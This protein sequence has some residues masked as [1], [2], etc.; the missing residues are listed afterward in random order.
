MQNLIQLLPHISSYNSQLNTPKQKMV[1]N[2]FYYFSFIVLKQK[3]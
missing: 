3:N 2:F 1:N